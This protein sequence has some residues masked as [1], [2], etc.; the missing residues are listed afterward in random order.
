MNTAPSTK[1]K[2]YVLE[3][4]S[5]SE[6]G[7][8]EFWFDRNKK[9]EPECQDILHALTA[10]VNE[11]LIHPTEHKYVADHSY[12]PVPLDEARLADELRRSMTPYAVDPD[13]FY[14][15]VATDAGRKQD[16]VNR[17]VTE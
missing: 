12:A 9:G 16:L 10:L 1:K 7:S 4:C 13:T 17:R 8:W 14:W 15:F 6:C 3:L 5:E 11:K 2:I